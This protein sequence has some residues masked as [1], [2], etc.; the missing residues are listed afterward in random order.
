MH[1]IIMNCP[2][3]KFIDHKD[4]NGLNNQKEN[5]RICTKQQN[6]GNSKIPKTNKIWCKRYT[7]G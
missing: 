2:D 7:L 3:G 1:R 6:S 4:G 5:L